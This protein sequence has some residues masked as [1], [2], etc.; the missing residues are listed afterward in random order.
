LRAFAAELL[1]NE[2]RQ[3]PRFFQCGERLVR[4]ARLAV[5]LIGILR[6]DRRDFR[7]P[8]GEGVMMRAA[9]VRFR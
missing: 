2:D 1:Q 7:R 4:E 5:D 6:G 9:P 3:K 8:V